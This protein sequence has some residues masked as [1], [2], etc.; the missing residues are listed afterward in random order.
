MGIPYNSPSFEMKDMIGETFTAVTNRGN[1][2]LY[3]IM[4]NGD[5]FVFHHEQDCCESVRIEE[6]VGDLDDLIDSPILE[7]EEVGGKSKWDNEEGESH[8][9]TFY[10]F[11]TIKGHVNVRW[12]G[13]SNGY[14]S[15]SVDRAFLKHEAES[16]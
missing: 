16:D 15:E 14:Y 10:K 9:W 7:A 2:E 1:K 4:S 3:F 11:G 8:T 13:T 12:Y 6:I 5:R